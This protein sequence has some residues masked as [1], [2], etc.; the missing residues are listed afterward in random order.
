MVEGGIYCY[1]WDE[2]IYIVIVSLPRR[3]FYFPFLTRPVCIPAFKSFTLARCTYLPVFTCGPKL[4]NPEL[5]SC[6]IQEG[7]SLSHNQARESRSLL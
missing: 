7:R 3:Q 5:A 1:G 2:G 4:V 6:S